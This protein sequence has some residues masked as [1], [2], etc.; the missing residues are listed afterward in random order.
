MP[1]ENKAT[2]MAAMP[3]ALDIASRCQPKALDRGSRKRLKVY[4]MMAAKLTITPTKAAAQ[5]PQPG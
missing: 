4:G 2:V 5:T 1:G 3:N